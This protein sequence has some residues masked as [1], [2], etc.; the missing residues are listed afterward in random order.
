AKLAN[1]ISKAQVSAERIIEILDASPEV[2]DQADAVEAP[3]LRG[4]VDFDHVS[5]AYAPR[6]E[7]R[8]GGAGPTVLRDI[9]L[10]VPAG[11]MVPLVGSS[12]AGKT[13]LVSLI[14]RF[15]DP[16]Q[17]C[18][19]IDGHDI[20]R[21]RLASLRRQ[22]SV[23]LQEAVLFPATIWENIAYGL[24]EAPPGFGPTWLASLRD[25]PRA[26]AVMARV[27]AAAPQ[28][29]A[30]EVIAQLPDGY[31]TVIGERG[32]TLSGGQ[33]QRIAIAR[34]MIR[35]A[36]ILILDEPTTGLDAESERLVME[37]LERLMR[38]RT[39]FV[40]AHCLSTVRRAHRI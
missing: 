7:L 23:V 35:D 14:P 25:K 13:T 26:E 21:L 9:D 36:P 16:T 28:A 10:S 39:T 31:D 11:T 20:R 32:A 3:A 38:G 5:F 22:V 40:I 17:G 18:V 33:R 24:E 2:R 6:G 27:V 29:N 12:G 30:H 37:A 4:A 19:R 8:A 15:Y 1:V 34:A